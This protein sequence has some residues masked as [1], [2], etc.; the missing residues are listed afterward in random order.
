MLNKFLSHVQASQDFLSSHLKALAIGVAVL[1][2]LLI[3]LSLSMALFSKFLGYGFGDDWNPWHFMVY[4]P[5]AFELGSLK[6]HWIFSLIAPFAVMFV[7]VAAFVNQ[8]QNDLFGNARWATLLEMKK[9]RLLEKTGVFLGRYRGRTVCAGGEGNMIIVAPTRSGKSAGII[10]PFLLRLTKTRDKQKQESFVVFDPK[11]EL[12]E[13]TSGHLQKHGYKC[14][15]WRPGER[16]D[17]TGGKIFTHRYNPI[18][19]VSRDK[20]LRIDDLEKIAEIMIPKRPDEP[21]IWVASSR[22]LF[23]AIQLYLL[24]T[25]D[26]PKTLGE[27]VRFCKRANFVEWLKAEVTARKDELDRVCVDNLTDFANKDYRL[28]SNILT[29][30]LSYF[31]IFSNP[32]LDASTSHSD[33]DFRQLR[34]ER[35]GIYIGVSS[36][37]IVRYG[38]LIAVLFQQVLDFLL[39]KEKINRDTDPYLVRFI[40]EEL[41]ALGHMKQIQK[42]TGLIGSY[43]ISTMGVI[44]DMPQLYVIYGKDGAKAFINAKFK[45][46]YASND[47]ESAEMVSGW[48]GPTT[49]KQRS[50]SSQLGKITN[51]QTESSTRK[52]LMSADQLMKLNRKKMVVS[53]EGENP[54]MINKVMW[55]NDSELK[56][57]VYTS[58]PAVTPCIDAII[59]D[60]MKKNNATVKSVEVILGKTEENIY[61][62]A[63][64][65]LLDAE[66][67]E[68]DVESALLESIVKEAE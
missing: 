43:G 52:P 41:S 60:I 5:Y 11:E 35:M 47:S 66:E 58:K 40:L 32:L 68:E 62:S 7:L 30:F 28:Q 16:G 53:V 20:R 8:K 24:D 29:S 31:T 21:P 49:V 54:I 59:D 33:F 22:D 50:N 18:D 25:D 36:N 12:F 55:F 1:G 63:Q 34:K 57:C 45:V 42:T 44:Q 51:S 15:I 64:S 38:E 26:R 2:G 10:I 37:N 67:R 13:K 4:G 27:M 65:I 19:F 6:N 3:G 48:L 9:A 39:M 61:Q 46:V 17:E 56:K 14:F 23:V